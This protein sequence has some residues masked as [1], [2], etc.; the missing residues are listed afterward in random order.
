MKLWSKARGGWLAAAAVALL[1][2]AAARGQLAGPIKDLYMPLETYSNGMVK[3]QI[4]AS[5][6]T[7]PDKGGDVTATGVRFE[8]LGEDG[9]TQAVVR[10]ESCV[11]NREART[12]RS[13]DPIRIE[14]GGVAI[15]GKGF[16]LDM[17][18]QFVR[19][20]DQ[21]QVVMQRELLPEMRKG[22]PLSAVTKPARK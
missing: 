3:T 4:H 21:V 19:I 1:A 6:A 8:L 12:A 20:L 16:T 7:L 22:R 10:A 11:V 14:K 15:A 5:S 18:N 9:G 17:T 13:D 2:P